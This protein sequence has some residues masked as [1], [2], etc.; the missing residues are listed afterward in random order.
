MTALFNLLA[1]L[2]VATAFLGWVNR[3]WL[4]LPVGVSLVLGGLL[5]AL[6]V[7]VSETL[8][9]AATGA[10]EIIETVQGIDFHAALMNGMLA[11]LLFASSLEIDLDELRGR[12]LVVAVTAT[13][14]VV[15]STALVG[16]GA[17]LAAQAVGLPLTLPWALVLG[18]IV[19]PTDPVAVMA[20]LAGVK[21]PES[22]R[23]DIAG[24]SLFNDGVAVVIFAVLLGL[25]QGS[26]SPTP[27]AVATFFLREVGGAL[28]LGAACGYVGYLAM[29]KVDDYP[30][31]VLI[32][33]A[34]CCGVFALATKL[35]ASGPLAVVAA[36]LLI[37]HRGPVD[38]MSDT[39]QDYLFGFW[40][41]VDH[42]LNA[43]LF[44]LIGL[45]FL[46]MP[47]EASLFLY[48][49]AIVAITLAA[50]LVSVSAAV[51]ALARR[52]VFAPGTIPILTWAGVRGG[53]SIA[54]ALSIADPAPRAAILAGAYGVV[55]FTIIVQGL[56]LAPL[57]RRYVEP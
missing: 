54:L 42:L 35:H 44:F 40:H 11:F 5:V 37:G 21:L 29:R 53:I 26:W 33:L 22:M 57:A 18:V 31:E 38:A 23:V 17:W 27:A 4:D 47:L 25:A 56:T 20:A 6:A 9:P 32:S 16:G 7:R 48:A 24:E 52:V 12:G 3:R 1:T 10:R 55:L 13:G 14:G 2:L 15:L 19:S 36:G 51:S 49:G 50:R 45:E 46:I 8:W 28:L 43:I 39:T 30:L 34:I 41:L